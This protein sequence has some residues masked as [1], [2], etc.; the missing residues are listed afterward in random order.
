MC[1]CVRLGPVSGA[2][3]LWED[4]W[5]VNMK[6]VCERLRV[7]MCHVCWQLKKTVSDRWT[8]SKWVSLDTRVH[9]SF[10]T[11]TR[12]HIYIFTHAFNHTQT[13][14]QRP[15]S[16]TQPCWTAKHTHTL[17]GIVHMKN[18]EVIYSTSCCVKPVWIFFFCGTQKKISVFLV[19]TMKVNRILWSPG[20]EMEE[21]LILWHWINTWFP[22]LTNT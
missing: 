2:S 3:L 4:C 9:F 12:S 5:C 13:F 1:V 6:R 10:Q 8:G 17:K 22:R 11:H 19:Q 18:E 16:N 15:T 14:P 7:Y 21:K 20:H